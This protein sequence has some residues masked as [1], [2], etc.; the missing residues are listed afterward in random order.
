M[1]PH[2]DKIK[3]KG[4]PKKGKKKKGYQKEKNQSS[5]IHF[6]GTMWMQMYDAMVQMLIALQHL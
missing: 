6:G 2:V 4:A 3:R 5:V 1:C